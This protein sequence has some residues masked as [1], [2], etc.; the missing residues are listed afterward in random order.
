MPN[1]NNQYK[2]K[3]KVKARENLKIPMKKKKY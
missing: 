1:K 2:K 3:L